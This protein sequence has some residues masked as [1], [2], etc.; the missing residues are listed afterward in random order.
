MYAI[1]NC[2]ICAYVLRVIYGGEVFTMGSELGPKGRDIKHYMLRDKNGR[3]RHF[4]RKIDFLPPPLCY[5]CFIGKIESSGK[6]RKRK[7]KK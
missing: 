3:I 7:W 1:G 5:Y 6:K 4:K 2:F